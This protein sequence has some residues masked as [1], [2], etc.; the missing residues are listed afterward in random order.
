[1]PIKQALIKSPRL[2]IVAHKNRDG[3]IRCVQDR[4]WDFYPGA[5]ALF[6][7]CRVYS[8]IPRERKVVPHYTCA[9]QSPPQAFVK[10]LYR[11]MPGLLTS[12]ELASGTTDVFAHRTQAVLL[13]QHR[14]YA[15]KKLVFARD[16]NALSSL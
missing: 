4:H 7:S 10:P 13:L 2:D 12:Y 5:V 16:H 15:G 8:S 3:V 6:L 14:K 1:V 9:G 11:V